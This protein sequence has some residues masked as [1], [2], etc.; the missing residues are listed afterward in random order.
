MMKTAEQRFAEA[1][2]MLEALVAEGYDCGPVRRLALSVTAKV[3]ETAPQPDTPK[4]E[5]ETRSTRPAFA[6]AEFAAK[7][8]TSE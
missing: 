6:R 3:R 8:E 4:A 5:S 2:A 7:R 1:K